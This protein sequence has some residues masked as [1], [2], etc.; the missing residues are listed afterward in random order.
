MGGVARQ[1]AGYL[2]FLAAYDFF[3][4][5]EVE[6]TLVG[7]ADGGGDAAD[8]Q[9]REGA[10]HP[11]PGAQAWRGRERDGLEMLAGKPTAY[12][13]AKGACRPP[14]AS[15]EELQKLLDGVA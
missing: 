3:L 11:E 4:G 10:L 1:P 15:V 2:Q 6:I 8:A 14:V 5:P 13:C 7:P 9:G 12:V